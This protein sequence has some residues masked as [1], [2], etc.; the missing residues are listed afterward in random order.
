MFDRV[1]HLTFVVRDLE[2]AVLRYQRDLGIQSIE[3]ESVPHR[4]VL[5]ARFWVGNLW[6]VL[7]QP[8]SRG[9]PLEHLREH[10]EGLL[11]VSFQVQSLDAA[12]AEVAARGLT[13]RGQH[14]TGV[15]GWRVVDLDT[16]AISGAVTQL[17]EVQSQ[18]ELPTNSAGGKHFNNT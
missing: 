4:G 9:A 1:H 5:T 3:R 7:V 8:I 17:C 6:F 13:T 14:R 2:E 16:P 15:G 11:L 18:S 12:L 10:G